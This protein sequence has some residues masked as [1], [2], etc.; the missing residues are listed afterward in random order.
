MKR[1]FDFTAAFVGMIVLSPLM[2]VL[3]VLV[4]LQDRHSPFYIATR[5]GAG[6]RCCA[7]W[8]KPIRLADTANEQSGDA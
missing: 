6:E 8:D 2:L 1:L 3:C 7:I 4:W 5:M